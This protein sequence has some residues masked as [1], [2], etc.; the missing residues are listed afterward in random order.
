MERG[1]KRKT[2]GA[3]NYLHIIKTTSQSSTAIMKKTQHQLNKI[4]CTG[5][6]ARLKPQLLSGQEGE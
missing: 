1:I 4:T 3:G 6:N 5:N 2:G